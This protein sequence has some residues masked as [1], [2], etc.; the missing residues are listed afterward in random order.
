MS[1]FKEFLKEEDTLQQDIEDLQGKDVEVNFR[2]VKGVMGNYFSS[3]H[4]SGKIVKVNV[5]KKSF[6]LEYDEL[7]MNDETMSGGPGGSF[8]AYKSSFS[9]DDID[10]VDDHHGHISIEMKP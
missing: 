10:S 9:F 1:L 7:R 4:L 6:V 5:E 3:V 2:Q 8:K